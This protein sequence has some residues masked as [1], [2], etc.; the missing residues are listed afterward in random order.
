MYIQGTVSFVRPPFWIIAT[1]VTDDSFPHLALSFLLPPPNLTPRDHTTDQLHSPRKA[2]LGGGRR[3][4]SF[5]T[6]LALPFWEPQGPVEGPT[7]RVVYTVPGGKRATCVVTV[8][9]QTYKVCIDVHRRIDVPSG[10]VRSLLLTAVRHGPQR[11]PYPDPFAFAPL[12]LS[13]RTQ[14]VNCVVWG[15]PDAH[16][17]SWGM[18]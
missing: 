10:A 7:Y 12:G 8:A 18:G 15:F 6:S 13:S 16:L 2:T 14:G 1:A 3:G 9:A 11:R 5:A 17:K 4:T